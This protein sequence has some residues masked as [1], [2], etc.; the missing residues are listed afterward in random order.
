MI[1][2]QRG[3]AL[4]VRSTNCTWVKVSKRLKNSRQT[5]Y[6]AKFEEQKKPVTT[7]LEKD[8][9]CLHFVMRLRCNAL[10]ESRKVILSLEVMLEY[11]QLPC[12]F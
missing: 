4:P 11:P 12:M 1:G 2:K 9:V 3:S 10:A 8:G 5:F 6:Y 7:K